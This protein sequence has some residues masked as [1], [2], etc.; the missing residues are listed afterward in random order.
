MN[1]EPSIG[2]EIQKQRPAVIISNDLANKYLNRVQV[3]PLTSQVEKIYP[4][5]AF[6]MLKKKKHR[7]LTNQ[8]MTASKKRL[9][10]KAGVLSTADM[11]KV[12][13]ALKIQLEL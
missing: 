1:F 2:G 7:A 12:E 11:S 9:S 8:I 5:E 3:I 10:K 6:V 13:E 4:G